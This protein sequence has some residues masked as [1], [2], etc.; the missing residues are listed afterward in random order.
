MTPEPLQ[1]NSYISAL[2]QGKLSESRL[3]SR[4]KKRYEVTTPLPSV[5][6]LQIFIYKV[7]HVHRF[8][9]FNVIALTESQNNTL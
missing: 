3:G 9:L 6:S 7:V 5:T 8:R 1:R 2:K 4:P